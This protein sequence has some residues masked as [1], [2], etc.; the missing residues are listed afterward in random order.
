MP[1]VGEIFPSKYL[2]Y[3]DLGGQP[4][5]YTIKAV[6]LEEAFGT[7]KPVIYFNETDKAMTVNVTNA[8]I[9]TQL[10]EDDE[11][12][13][14]VGAKVQLTP[15]MRNIAGQLKKVVDVTNARR[16]QAA[17]V[18]QAPAPVIADDIPF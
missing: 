16:G 6:K 9:L 15:T 11:I 8:R 5:G 17:P 4:K 14:W 3:D 2:S 7:T 13:N 1:K 18:A 12:D 10:L